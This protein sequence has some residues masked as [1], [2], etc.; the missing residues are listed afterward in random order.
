[1]YFASRGMIAITPEYRLFNTH[2]TSPLNC[3]Q[4]ANAVMNFIKKNAKNLGINS[5][6]S[7]L[8]ED[9]LE[10]IWH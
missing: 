10:V 3:V 9:L 8:V 7:L 1:M 4:D 6:R 5:K 2:G